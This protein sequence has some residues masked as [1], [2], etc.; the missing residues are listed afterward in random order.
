MP[1]DPL[2]QTFI[3]I[4]ALRDILRHLVLKTARDSGRDPKIWVKELEREIELTS[5]L[6]QSVGSQAP[7]HQAFTSD[8]S[9]EVKS[10]FAAF[11][12]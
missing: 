10:F 9:Q 8:V 3:R 12:K 1:K 7:D 4:V 11:A 5:D 2:D 6:A